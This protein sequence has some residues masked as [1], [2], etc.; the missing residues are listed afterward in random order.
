MIEAIDA[1][2]TGLA[3]VFKPVK[4]FELELSRGNE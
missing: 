3:T 2:A 1:I 4:N